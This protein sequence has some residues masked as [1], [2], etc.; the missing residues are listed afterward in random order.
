[1]RTCGAAPRRLAQP[2]TV[3]EIRTIVDVIDRTSPIGIRDAAMILLG[4]ASAMRRSEIVTL[5]LADVEHKPA[6]CCSPFASP[7]WSKKDTANRLP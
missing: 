7:R 5:A 3:D 2:L 6:A 4:Y 1:M